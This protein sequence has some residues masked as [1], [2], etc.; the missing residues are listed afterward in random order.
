MRTQRMFLTLA[1]L[2]STIVLPWAQS[3][4]AQDKA[5]AI[6]Q[7]LDKNGDGKISLEEWPN[8]PKAFKMIDT[9]GDGLLS[10][11]ELKARFGSEGAANG[12][13]NAPFKPPGQAGSLYFVD[14]HS[15]MDGYVDEERVLSLMARGGVHRTILSAQKGRTWQSV[16]EFAQRSPE[17]ITAAAVIKGGG[18]H[19]GG[20][21][22]GE[23]FN[24][25]KAQAMNP[26]IN[27]MAEVL[28][29]HDGLG[30][31]FNIQVDL[32]DELVQAALEV[33]KQKG[34]PFIIH[35]EFA[36]LSERKRAN[37]MEQLSSLLE[38]NPQH[39]FVLIHMGL[40][41]EPDV[42]KLLARHRNLHFTLSATS[43][44]FKKTADGTEAKPFV[45][46][47]DG[48]GFKPQWRQLFLDFPNQFLFALD[49]ANNMHWMEKP[50]LNQMRHWWAAMNGIPTAVASAIAHG[51]AERLWRLPPRTEG[52]ML[53]PDAALKQLGPVTGQSAN[54]P[55]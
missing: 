14:A 46:I 10:P 31:Y 2:L 51:N 50:Y 45:D 27:A 13:G 55:L 25:L 38:A 21:P 41:E 20:E 4:H 3:A 6:L 40:L 15:Q 24:R 49:C 9:D 54:R 33:A 12:P 39:P 43:S 36:S 32:S 29:Y 35:I 28:V 53:P 52:S 19:G 48:P 47:F 34:W 5:T 8:P 23:Y 1:F 30:R 11:E 22:R 7:K 17:Q 42:R 18:Y 26:A 44:M 16:A 37:Y